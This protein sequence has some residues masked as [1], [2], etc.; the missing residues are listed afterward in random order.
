MPTSILS[1]PN[2]ILAKILGDECLS[3]GDLASAEGTCQLFRAN[4]QEYLTCR[5]YTFRVDATNHP[6]W[7]LI[8]HLLKNP[9]LAERFT[10]I[11]VEWERRIATDSSTWTSDWE[12]SSKERT[13]IEKLC[14]TWDIQGK[15]K[16]NILKGKNSEA[17]L[18][19]LL[20]F[21]PNLKSLDLGN[22]DHRIVD[23][24]HDNSE[25][26]LALEA[27][28][29]YPDGDRDWER[30]YDRSEE[31][32]SKNH[33]L[34]FFDNLRYKKKNGSI[35]GPK[36]LL[37]GL[38]KV[39][40]FRIG[41]LGGLG[42]AFRGPDI[43]PVFL[44]PRIRSI[45]AFGGVD[46][47]GSFYFSTHYE[48]HSKG[49]SPVKYL[50]LESHRPQ[51]YVGQ[52][53]SFSEEY[54]QAI[55]DITGNL[56]RLVIKNKTIDI[57]GST[58]Q[59]DESVGRIFLE[60]NKITLKPTQVNINGGSFSAGGVFDEDAERRKE[61]AM[62]QRLFENA[63]ARQG[64]L[65][66]KPSPLQTLEPVLFSYILTFLERKNVYNLML[67]CK[68]FYEPCYHNIWSWFAFLDSYETRN[69]VNR[70]VLTDDKATHLQSIIQRVGVTGFKHLEHIEIDHRMFSSHLSV[71]STGLLESITNEIESGNTPRL[72]HILLDLTSYGSDYFTS[73]TEKGS[74]SM[75]DG[76]NFLR[77][78]KRYSERKGPQEFT[79]HLAMSIY[80]SALLELCDITKLTN[81]RLNTSWWWGL[82]DAKTTA[83]IS[84]RLLAIPGQLRV[85]TLAGGY[86]QKAPK[87][88]DSL[89]DQLQAL[90]EVVSDMKSLTSLT[91]TAAFLFHPSFLLLPPANVKNLS[92]AGR[93]STSWWQKFASY[94]FTGV[95]R[96]DLSCQDLNA[97]ERKAVRSSGEET[98]KS[99]TD[100]QLNHIEISGLKWFSI[101]ESEG[102]TYPVDFFESVLK[103][104]TQISP[105]CL[106]VIAKNKASMCSDKV[107]TRIPRIVK[108]CG[109]ELS[110]QL[111]K[112][113]E[114]HSEDFAAK[115]LIEGRSL[116]KGYQE[117]MENTSIE[118]LI[119][120]FENEFLSNFS[121]LCA[122][123]L[124]TRLD[125][126]ID[127]SDDEKKKP[128]R[129]RR[130]M[131]R[132]L[133]KP[134]SDSEVS[135]D[136]NTN[137]DEDEGEDSDRQA[138]DGSMSMDEAAFLVD[139]LT[140]T[141]RSERL[142]RQFIAS[143]SDDDVGSGGDGPVASS[144]GD[145]FEESD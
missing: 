33:T 26:A 36:Q 142:R 113:F 108:K 104:N 85:L 57:H 67:S 44:F 65:K 1:F 84:T 118:A 82:E 60:R 78:L 34:F 42:Q 88:L 39:E 32:E 64:G 127:E 55:A 30:Y 71:S 128:T 94:P 100:I 80:G 62:R 13:R 45:E 22:V 29:G 53:F 79:L 144:L 140:A 106:R 89:W 143:G 28:G 4:I 58:K 61:V 59:E 41:S 54:S 114:C 66:I 126:E 76:H 109:D 97:G 73:S 91:V 103:R 77:T 68:A 139:N 48:P 43:F 23:Y 40:D 56:E 86:Y 112:A 12:W 70:S 31:Y 49:P 141:S 111:I 51:E 35:E 15:T 116:P 24:S 131:G 125:D 83:E 120:Q 110:R 129:K 72:K 107:R 27:I 135:D 74:K 3:N 52:Q 75:N 137:V 17:L 46:S 122:G 136:D 16:S 9:K 11:I 95:E 6:T 123:A 121:N 38:A 14:Q 145:M 133:P 25:H 50:T 138:S 20:C 130:L 99:S 92:Y 47:G 21:T 37:P 81:L 132:G 96:L 87:G 98:H 115:R 7:K 119:K 63:R 90:Q 18:P 69:S 101:D 19:L 134:D 5:R 105:H 2:E 124:R 8:R 117:E 10:H 93:M 102:C